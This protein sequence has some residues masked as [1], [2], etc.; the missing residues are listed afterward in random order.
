[1]PKRLDIPKDLTSKYT[2]KYCE[3]L[4]MAD[5]E[6]LDRLFRISQ[7]LP[8]N[9]AK[10]NRPRNPRVTQEERERRSLFMKSLRAKAAAV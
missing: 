7:E 4:L 10:E 6:G 5:P 8:V 2:L 3:E 1:M 9:R